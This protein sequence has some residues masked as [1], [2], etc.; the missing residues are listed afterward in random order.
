MNPIELIMTALLTG[1]VNTSKE[2]IPDAYKSLKSLIK[3]RF[4]NKPRSQ[5]A[6]EE[7]EQDP[8]TCKNLLEK[9]LVEADLD[10]DEEIIKKAQEV[11][12]QVQSVKPQSNKYN[13]TFQG[14][15]KGNQ[16]GDRNSQ[17][18]TFS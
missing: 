15:A 3:N 13:T 8:E 17:T 4:S 7:Y 12:E 18:N 16:F 2:I 14:E 9:K 6:L 10:K 11:L 1:T 5:M